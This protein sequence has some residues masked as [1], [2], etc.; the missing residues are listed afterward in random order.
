MD[1]AWN[2]WTTTAV[3][4]SPSL[5]TISR[6][7]E[8]A[9]FHC[10]CTAHTYSLDSELRWPQQPSL[11]SSL[12]CAYVV[13]C[14]LHAG[15]GCTDF[16]FVENKVFTMQPMP[17]TLVIL[18]SNCLPR[19]WFS[20]VGRSD[21]A[22]RRCGQS[23][24]TW[25]LSILRANQ[26]PYSCPILKCAAPRCYR[27]CSHFGATFVLNRFIHSSNGHGFVQPNQYWVDTKRTQL[28]WPRMEACEVS[29]IFN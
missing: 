20:C 27:E 1:S 9:I 28:L 5:V 24:C 8:L 6:Q 25:F 21:I 15:G 3:S 4:I 10:Y 11:L 29:I 2:E 14:S 18:S 16:V 26:L 17:K 13:W 22:D 19:T 12:Y 23:H 7:H